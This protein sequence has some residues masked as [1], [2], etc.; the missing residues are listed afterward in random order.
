MPNRSQLEAGDPAQV[1][2]SQVA[3]WLDQH[4]SLSFEEVC[5]QR[6]RALNAAGE[7]PE[8]YGRTPK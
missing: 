1:Y 5:I 3:P 6:M 7:L 2:R 8:R 4:L